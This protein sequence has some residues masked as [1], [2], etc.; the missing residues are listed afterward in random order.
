[1]YWIAF[2]QCCTFGW[3]IR[4]KTSTECDL[5]G[6]HFICFSSTSLHH[7]KRFYF[8]LTNNFKL[9]ETSFSRSYQWKTVAR[10]SKFHHQKSIVTFHWDWLPQ[11][12]QYSSS[13]I[14][15]MKIHFSGSIEF[16]SNVKFNSKLV[17][18]SATSC[19]QID[20][21]PNATNQE[22]NWILE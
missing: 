19:Q 5:W 15:A 11:L 16:K 22:I 6:A 9:Q 20:I 13:H 17:L 2:V 1:M 21:Y 12:I 8:C 4:E 7:N 3:K 18:Y 10:E 14:D